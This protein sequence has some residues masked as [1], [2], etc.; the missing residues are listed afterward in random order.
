MAQAALWGQPPCAGAGSPF[1][2]A[3]LPPPVAPCA[4]GSL[5]FLFHRL[6]LC[7]PLQFEMASVLKILP[8]S[9]GFCSV[10]S[11]EKSV[12]TIPAHTGLFVLLFLT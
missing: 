6:R 3:P 9:Q 11:T 1:R 7:V 2:S 8:S 10:P 5:V 4:C 12:Q